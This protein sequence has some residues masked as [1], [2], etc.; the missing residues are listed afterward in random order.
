M[1]RF[2]RSAPVLFVR[3]ISIQHV[4]TKPYERR[5]KVLRR[6]GE[7]LYIY[8]PIVLPWGRRVPLIRWLNEF[9]I[10]RLVKRRI[11]KIGLKKFALWI[12]APVSEYLVGKLGE[13]LVVYDCTDAWWKFTDVP[14]YIVRRE[15]RLSER[16]DVLFA[17]TGMVY[18][19]KSRI[20]GNSHLFTC[21][22]DYEHFNPPEAGDNESLAA[23]ENITRP[24]IGYFGLID[25][26][27]LDVELLAKMAQ[28]HPDWSIV[29][30][31]PVQDR[32]CYV[33]KKYSNVHFIGLVSYE[34]LPRYVRYFDVAM[35]PYS[36]NEGT[37]YI[38]PTKLLEYMAAGKPVVSSD[39]PEIRRDYKNRVLL[40]KNTKEFVSGIE[41]ILDGSIEVPVEEN[42]DRSS[43]HSWE[44]MQYKMEQ[45]VSEK[46]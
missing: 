42:R 38:N 46:L 36:I 32:E 45:L 29:L 22:V 5:K 15:K 4:I 27:R 20:N 23:F 21:G 3:P 10:R 9:I 6:N 44:S 2:A 13:S 40:A 33:L 8:S 11:R 24:I 18:D 28:G 14:K 30:I 1:S 7:N 34:E 26:Q 35:I 43:R 37:R 17:G 25:R 16:A 31:G 39:I 19:E 41:G 12:Y